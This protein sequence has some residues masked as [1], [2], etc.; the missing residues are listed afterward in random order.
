VEDIMGAKNVKETRVCKL[1][2]ELAM[3]I[4]EVTKTFPKEEKYSMNIDL[5][6]NQSPFNQGLAHE[7]PIAYCLLPIPGRNFSPHEKKSIICPDLHPPIVIKLLS[8]SSFK[9]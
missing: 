7:L 5:N 3:E 9:T 8:H 1:G 4:F 2:F 6:L